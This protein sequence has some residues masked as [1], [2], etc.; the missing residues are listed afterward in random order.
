MTRAPIQPI[1]DEWIYLA[2]DNDDDGR[3][4]LI[5]GLSI[6]RRPERFDPI[7]TINGVTIPDGGADDAH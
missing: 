7:L 2:T 3:V 5:A 4:V 1:V 6:L